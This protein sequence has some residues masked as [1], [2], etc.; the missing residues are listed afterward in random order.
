MPKSLLT[1]CENNPDLRPLLRLQRLAQE[2]RAGLARGDMEVVGQASLLLA[3]ALAEWNERSA[4]MEITP[5]E[6][7]QIT[8]DT[9]NLL[10]ECEQ[11]LL[12]AMNRISEEL[13]RL[14]RA[15]RNTESVRASV[16]AL[17]GFRLDIE[18]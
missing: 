2:I 11:T 15:Q 18:R 9:Q 7:V 4:E 8:L 17:F 6:A 10:N 5:G 13:R 12:N 1:E 14:K 3:P 16:P